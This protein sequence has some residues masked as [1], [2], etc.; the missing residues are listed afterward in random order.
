MSS[1]EAS[2][3]DHRGVLKVK[4]LGLKPQRGAGCLNTKDDTRNVEAIRVIVI[5]TV[6]TSNEILI[7]ETECW[8]TPANTSSVDTERD[9]PVWKLRPKLFKLQL[10]ATGII[11]RPFIV[12]NRCL[13]L[14]VC[15]YSSSLVYGTW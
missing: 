13:A 14:S 12:I 4:E 7:P 5:V 1:S 2:D 11:P 10:R 3:D 8:Q 15:Q 9:H 6:Y